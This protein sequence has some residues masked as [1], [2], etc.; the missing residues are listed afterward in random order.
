MEITF[1]LFWLCSYRRMKFSFIFRCFCL[2]FWLGDSLSLPLE[3]GWLVLVSDNLYFLLRGE[4]F[5][6]RLYLILL[7]WKK[8][9][10]NKTSFQLFLN[11]LTDYI[12]YCPFLRFVVRSLFLVA[13]WERGNLLKSF[14]VRISSNLVWLSVLLKKSWGNCLESQCELNLLSRLCIQ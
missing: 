7:C 10:L 5:N 4:W 6:Y 2:I 1:F 9:R 14:S 12:L 3:R 13:H 8:K 11:A